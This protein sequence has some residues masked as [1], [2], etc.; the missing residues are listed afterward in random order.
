M[1]PLI[2]LL[3]I[4]LSIGAFVLYKRRAASKPPLSPLHDGT[5]MDNRTVQVDNMAFQAGD[6]IPGATIGDDGPTQFENQLYGKIG[7][8]AL[9]ALSNPQPIFG[10]D[11]DPHA[12][13]VTGD[14]V[15]L[16]DNE[17]GIDASKA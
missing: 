13:D 1:V 7:P 4:G 16:V 15:G 6:P 14:K 5:P 9:G 3:I 11:S 8:A 12:V 17:V 10:K 2:V